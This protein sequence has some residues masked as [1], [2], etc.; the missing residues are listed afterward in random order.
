M[1]RGDQLTIT[2]VEADL[3][4]IFDKVSAA[5]QTV[6]DYK[7]GNHPLPPPPRKV[8]AQRMALLRTWPFHYKTSPPM[9]FANSM[10]FVK[11]I[12]TVEI[13]YGAGAEP[14]ILVR[15]F[16]EPPTTGIFP[17]VLPVQMGV[18]LRYKLEAYCGTISSAGL[19]CF[20][21]I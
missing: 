20:I 11:P 3:V 10:C 5:S 8:P 13:S 12:V 19:K 2:V 21:L 15:N 17:K 18:V 4:R 6:E 1:G 7:G 16:P 14:L 9:Y